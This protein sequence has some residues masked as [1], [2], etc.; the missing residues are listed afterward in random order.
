MASNHAETSA[1]NAPS[2]RPRR[3]VDVAP[4][5]ESS[6]LPIISSSLTGD[7]FLVWS[8]AIKFALGARK[9]LSFIDGRAIR[10]NDN[11]DELNEW[12]RVD[13]MVITWILNSISKE[14]VDA[15]IYVSSARSLWLELEARYGGSNGP[16]IYSLEREVSLIS[17][18][19]M[20]VTTHFT[21]TKML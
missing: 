2:S 9:K 3:E 7:N 6:G 18:G 8:R 4:S 14:I 20:S 12:I 19:E 13:Y 21:K 11:S 15:F 16:M 5:V 1:A 10:P 17:Q